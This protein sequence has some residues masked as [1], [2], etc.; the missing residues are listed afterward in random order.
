VYRSGQTVSIR[1]REAVVGPG[2]EQTYWNV[3]HVPLHGPDGDVESVLLLANDVTEQV[4][5][6]KQIEE[7]WRTDCA[8][9]QWT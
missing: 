3:E 9:R 5:R 2:R 4:R 8:T 7:R 1:E 6:R